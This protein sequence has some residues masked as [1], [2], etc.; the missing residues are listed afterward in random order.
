LILNLERFFFAFEDSYEYTLRIERIES[1]S[2]LTRSNVLLS[3]GL[4]KGLNKEFLEMALSNVYEALSLSHKLIE[5][6]SI[7]L[8]QRS[9]QADIKRL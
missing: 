5:L 7:I 1:S 2:F 4:S 8:S 6:L 9:K 3:K